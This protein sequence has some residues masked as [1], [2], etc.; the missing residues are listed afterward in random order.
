MPAWVGLPAVP[1]GEPLAGPVRGRV[2]IR[3]GDGVTTEQVLP[4]GARIEPLA[5]DIG[6]LRVHAFATLDPGFAGRAVAC[7]G[8]LVL[9]GDSLGHGE[10]REQAALVLAS[11]GVRAV[12][13]RSWAPAFHRRLLDAGVLPLSFGRPVDLD[14]FAAGEEIELPTLPHGLEPGRPVAVRNLTRGTQL[15]VRHDLD[16]RA[17]AI[18]RGGGLLR[19][20]SAFREVRG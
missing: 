14:A 4:W 17:V 2:L 13:A 18:A 19:Y 3:C 16:G 11:L 12:I 6:A 15:D 20:G 5:G 10:P 8:G 9:A 7:G 1:L